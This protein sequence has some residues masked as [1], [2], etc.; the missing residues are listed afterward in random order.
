MNK[1]RKILASCMVFC[2]LGIFIN[3][4][5]IWGQSIDVFDFKETPISD[6]AKVFTALTG[7]NVVASK[8]IKDQEITL[9]L[10]GVSALE[11]LKTM[12][13]MNNLWFTE[14]DN[15]IRIMSTEDYAQDL[16]VRRDEKTFVYKLK[17]A[18]SLAV[19]DML[20]I[21]FGGRIRYEEPDETDSYGHVGTEIGNR[22]SLGGGFGNTAGFNQGGRSNRFSRSG[23]RASNTSRTNRQAF[24]SGNDLPIDWQKDISSRDIER[25]ERQAAGQ[26]LE[27]G[28]VLE[29]KS[30]L[31][32]VYVAVFPR[33]NVIAARSVDIQVLR[34]I[35][36]FIN[37]ID[38]PTSQVLLEG[39][40]LEITLDDDFS[41]FLDLNISSKN[42]KHQADVGNFS[43][44]FQDKTVIYQFIDQQL[45]ARLE[46]FEDNKKLRIIGTPMILCA[47]NAQGEFF[48]GEERPITISYDTEIREFEERTTEIVR[49]NRENRDIGT[50]LTVTPSINE[51]Q[52]VTMR[53][54]AEVSNVVEGGAIQSIVTQLGQ[55]LD[56]PVDTVDTSRIDNIIVA[57]N[58]STLAVGGLIRERDLD[59]D[60]KVPVLGDVPL[61]GF[62][63]K[64]KQIMK[65]KTETVFLITPHIMM[66]SSEGQYVSDRVLADLSDHP[67]VKKS[68]QRLLKYDKES[69]D[70]IVIDEYSDDQ[71]AGEI[72]SVDRSSGVA[73][74]GLGRKDG[75]TADDIFSVYRRGQYIG[76]VR[77]TGTKQE[78]L[79]VTPVKPLVI[80]DLQIGDR[81]VM[82]VQVKSSLGSYQPNVPVELVNN[83]EQTVSEEVVVDYSIQGDSSSPFDEVLEQRPGTVLRVNNRL[84]FA[85][86]GL[87]QSGEL[88][89]NDRLLIYRD[90]TYVGE[91][92]V[93]SI[94][95]N[96]AAVDPV[97][98]LTIKDVRI[99]DTAV[100]KVNNSQ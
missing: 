66:D 19:A 40:I 33:N 43:G 17:H 75:I 9:Y 71:K 70:F 42:G 26:G 72:L 64:K 53:F 83:F 91:V 13:K 20:E 74:I 100:Q 92:K 4:G 46:L 57:Q 80:S 67:F 49:G 30:Q 27:V 62:F 56:L 76:D 38:T 77:V 86:V 1:W 32:T 2:I 23:S 59:F 81:V 95:S 60:T 6:V 10:R 35:G 55:Q 90:D 28:D 8:N 52:T 25:L 93:R 85:I 50:R 47:N 45:E 7:K 22:S 98:A 3:S 58:N 48:I 36:E 73:V 78:M 18:S 65:Q 94:R 54:S 88:R 51:D 34:D 29:E 31:A 68:H 96:L 89:K 24:L 82:N 39:K 61:L 63:F 79:A 87:R 16:T 37:T 84:N 99:G 69:R 14:E 11:A 5:C 21:L 97:G 15:V 44:L 41:S 12:C